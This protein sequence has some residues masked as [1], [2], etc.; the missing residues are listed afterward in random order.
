MF[1]LERRLAEDDGMIVATALGRLT[2]VTPRDP[3]T[4]VYEPFETRAAD[5]LTQLASQSLGVDADPDRAQVVV[6]INA[7]DLTGDTGSGEVENGPALPLETVRRLG[8]D[9]RISAVIEDAA[10]APV[11]I[12]RT[13]RTIPAW[14]ARQIRHRD[15][16]CRF[17]GCERTRWVHSHHIVHWAYGGATNLDN[18]VTLCPYH[19]R[20]IHEGGWSIRGHPDGELTWLDEHNNTFN[21]RDLYWHTVGPRPDTAYLPYWLWPKTAR[22]TVDIS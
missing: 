21:P 11:G 16:G 7:A 5:A 15:R 3:A 19:H 10:G 12:G 8:C 18:L 6:H 17:P 9:G 2:T 4:C 22:D 13:A 1:R 20:L 14:L